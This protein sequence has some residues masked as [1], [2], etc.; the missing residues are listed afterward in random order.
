MDEKLLPQDEQNALRKMRQ[1]AKAVGAT[2]HDN[3][4]GGLSASLVLGIMRRD[5]YKCHRCGTR[6]DLNVHHKGHLKNP[7]SRWLAKKG[8]DNDPNNIVT[9]CKTCHDE[10]H[11]EDE[12][13]KK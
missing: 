6:K 13:G 9:L 5:R 4:E 3:G 11:V 2:L 1:E 8:R 7:A 10:I 12:G